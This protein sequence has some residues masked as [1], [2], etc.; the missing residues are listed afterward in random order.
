MHVG[1]TLTQIQRDRADTR[2]ENEEG[3]LSESLLNPT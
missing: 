2:W 3:N 1:V